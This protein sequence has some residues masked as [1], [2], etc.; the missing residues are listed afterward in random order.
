MENEIGQYEKGGNTAADFSA[1]HN[2]WFDKVA[3]RS[4]EL[5]DN[6]NVKKALAITDKEA[7]RDNLEKLR[8]T[9][10]DIPYSKEVH[11]AID[12]QI[13]KI[14]IGAYKEFRFSFG[15]KRHGHGRV[16]ATSEFFSM[17]EQAATYGNFSKGGKMKNYSSDD[18]RYFMSHLDRMAEESENDGK[19]HNIDIE[20]G[21][22]G[23]KIPFNADSYERLHRF[24]RE[25]IKEAAELGYEKGGIVGLLNTKIK[26]W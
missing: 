14:L 26:L 11:Q 25:E 15:G 8:E 17:F 3:D 4:D 21:K 7:T 22:Q 2:A 1:D 16:S 5:K 23:I 9:I 18:L 12:G 6:E 13:K 10:K 20:I 19:E 24:I